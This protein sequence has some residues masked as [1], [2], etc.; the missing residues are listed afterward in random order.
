MISFFYLDFRT[1]FFKQLK[2]QKCHEHFK[3]FAIFERKLHAVGPLDLVV[4]PNFILFS[5]NFNII[6]NSFLRLKIYH[7]KCYF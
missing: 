6:F 4:E 1:T 2:A 7:D 5:D 3:L